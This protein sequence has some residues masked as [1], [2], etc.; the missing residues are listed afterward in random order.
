MKEFKERPNIWDDLKIKIL[1]Y[2]ARLIFYVILKF[3]NENCVNIKTKHN[4]Q[5]LNFCRT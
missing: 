2:Y 5:F 4:K 3:Q 1:H